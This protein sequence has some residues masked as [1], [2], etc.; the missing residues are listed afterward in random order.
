MKRPNNPQSKAKVPL[1]TQTL[2][3]LSLFLVNKIKS[4]H[5]VFIFYDIQI[6]TTILHQANLITTTH[7]SAVNKTCLHLWTGLLLNMLNCG[8][9]SLVGTAFINQHLHYAMSY[10]IRSIMQYLSKDVA[11]CPQR[12]TCYTI[13]RLFVAVV[14]PLNIWE[15]IIIYISNN[16]QLETH[17]LLHHSIST[18]NKSIH[19]HDSKVHNLYKALNTRDFSNDSILQPSINTSKT[20]SLLKKMYLLGLIIDSSLFDFTAGINYTVTTKAHCSEVVNSFFRQWIWKINMKYMKQRIIT[21]LSFN[22]A[23]YF[24]PND[25]CIKQ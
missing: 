4:L 19:C 5:L 3:S 12:P 2:L 21:L 22:S 24:M 8:A 17:S 11:L 20:Q 9:V 25:L 10:I 18:S 15:L 13:K 23:I 16:Y 6:H 1:I 7:S 14:Q